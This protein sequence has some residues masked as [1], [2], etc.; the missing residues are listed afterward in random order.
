MSVD[1]R[2]RLEF[3]PTQIGYIRAGLRNIEN[4]VS[5]AGSSFVHI[6]IADLLADITEQVVEQTCIE[7]NVPPPSRTTKCHP[8]IET[9]GFTSPDL[10][11]WDEDPYLGA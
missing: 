9:T 4:T 10:Y 1:A 5:G 6:E 2:I 3:T 11:A 8:S 7:N